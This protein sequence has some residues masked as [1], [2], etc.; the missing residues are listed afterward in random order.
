MKWNPVFKEQLFEIM[1]SELEKGLLFN[2]LQKL[3]KNETKRE[4][5]TSDIT[6]RKRVYGEVFK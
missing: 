1:E 5:V 3:K 2:D 6:I 4:P